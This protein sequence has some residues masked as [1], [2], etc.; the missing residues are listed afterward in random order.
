MKARDDTDTCCAV[1]NW[2]RAAIGALIVSAYLAVAAQAQ[3]PS[4]GPGAPAE[5]TP[6]SAQ[7]LAENAAT[8]DKLLATHD[9][10]GLSNQILRPADKSLTPSN[11]AWARDRT[12]AG[13]SVIVPIIYSR[14]LWIIGSSV[15]QLASLKETSAVITAY[16]LLV[17][18]ADGVKCEDQSAPSRHIETIMLNYGEQLR[19]IST[20]SD[21]EK[22]RVVQ[23]AVGLEQKTFPLRQNDNYLCRFGLWRQRKA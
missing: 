13:A 11:L 9:F 20:L 1:P 18:Y 22:A 17:M 14:A 19:Y 15:P 6:P 7:A 3:Q 5:S 4:G 23:L 12:L 2:P 21:E 8:L 10:T 16:V